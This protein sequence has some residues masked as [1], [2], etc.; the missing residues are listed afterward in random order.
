MRTGNGTQN[1]KRVLCFEKEVLV[2]ND[3]PTSIHIIARK[4][5]SNGSHLPRNRGD[6]SEFPDYNPS[7]DGVQARVWKTGHADRPYPRTRSTACRS[8][9]PAANLEKSGSGWSLY[10]SVVP[11]FVIAQTIGIFA[12]SE[13]EKIIAH[14]S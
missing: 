3:L 6:S 14:E 7:G 9:A 13:T 12:L 8:E 10:L 5:N 1:K 11:G 4:Y 2:C